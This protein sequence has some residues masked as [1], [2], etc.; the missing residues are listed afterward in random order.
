[1]S[2]WSYLVL[3]IFT[4]KYGMINS[5]LASGETE[6]HI[7]VICLSSQAGM[8]AQILTP[9]DRQPISS[10]FIHD[11]KNEGDEKP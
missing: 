7:K 9:M 10:T 1:M 6:A 11:T 2:A 8:I 5:F 4:V 3:R